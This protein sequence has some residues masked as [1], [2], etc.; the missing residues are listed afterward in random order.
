MSVNNTKHYF[1]TNNSKM[2]KKTA[3]LTHWKLS[4]AYKANRC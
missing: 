3:Y 4:K 2:K 1:N